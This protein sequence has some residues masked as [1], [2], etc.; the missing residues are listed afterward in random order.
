MKKL[1][2]LSFIYLGLG[3]ILG[4]FHREFTKFNNFSGET[5]LGTAH[6]HTLVLGFLF[7][8]IILLLD[9]N[10]DVSS[11]KHF[12]KWLISYNIG[13]ISLIGTIVFRGVLEVLSKDFAGLPH[14]AGLGHAIFGASLIWFMIILNK[15]IKK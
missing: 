8:L 2:N 13:L 15:K 7:F 10:F 4:V 11:Y 6:T 12:N 5:V 3:L 14:M 9:K 1:F